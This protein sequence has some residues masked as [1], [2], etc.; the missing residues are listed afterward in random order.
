MNGIIYIKCLEPCL[1]YSNDLLTTTVL[2]CYI[3]MKQAQWYKRK[4]KTLANTE[5]KQTHLQIQAWLDLFFS[6]WMGGWVWVCQKPA[7]SDILQEPSPWVLKSNLSLE[8]GTST[9]V[10]SCLDWRYTP[11]Q[12]G[13]WY[14]NS[15]SCVCETSPLPTKPSLQW[16]YLKVWSASGPSIRGH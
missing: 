5:I 4:K 15:T 10:G 6:I 7:L 8:S 16:G 12:P 9:P 2:C 3:N 14:S 13:Y 11:P 1:A